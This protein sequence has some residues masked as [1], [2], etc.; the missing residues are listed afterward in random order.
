MAEDE[1]IQIKVTRERYEE[2]VNIDDDIHFFELTNRIAYDYMV[3]FVSDGNGSYL[4]VDDAR[5]K[6]KTIPRKELSNYI[7]KFVKAIGD[8]FVN[9]PNGAELEDQS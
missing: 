5:K 2:I 4:S 9:P 7:V 3:Q 1:V 8:A 6:F